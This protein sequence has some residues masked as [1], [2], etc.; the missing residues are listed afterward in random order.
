[1]NTFVKAASIAAVLFLTGS[2]AGMSSHSG[3]AGQETQRI[4]ALSDI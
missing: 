2:A 3:Y 4:K 1:M